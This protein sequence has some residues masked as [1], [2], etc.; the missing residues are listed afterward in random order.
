MAS[1]A[2]AEL[3]HITPI[4]SLASKRMDQRTAMGEAPDRP[5]VEAIANQ[6]SLHSA[7]GASKQDKCFGN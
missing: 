6:K 3:V 7:A 4:A 5:R 2:A 1:K